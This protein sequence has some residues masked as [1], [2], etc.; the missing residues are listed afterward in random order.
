MTAISKDHTF[1]K[2]GRHYWL[3][4][5][6][7]YETRRSKGFVRDGFV[8]DGYSIPHL[9]EWMEDVGLSIIPACV[10][11][12]EYLIG[13][14]RLRA[15]RNFFSLMRLCNGG[16]V[17]PGLLYYGARML[18]E[19]AWYRYERHRRLMRRPECFLRIA[20]NYDDAVR[21]VKF[22]KGDIDEY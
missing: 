14:P 4:G 9:G 12:W 18:C 2:I 17:L 15:D 3:R 16:T 19:P 10:H 1:V 11:D 6:L 5:N 7:N 21:L 8:F 20:K 22:I 13:I